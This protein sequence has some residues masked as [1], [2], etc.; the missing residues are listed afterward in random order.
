MLSRTTR[1]QKHKIRDID[2]SLKATNVVSNFYFSPAPN[3][4]H[5]RCTEK[6]HHILD[7]ISVSL[8]I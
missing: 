6:L 8:T 5:F 1:R 3:K 7:L 4:Q 2:R